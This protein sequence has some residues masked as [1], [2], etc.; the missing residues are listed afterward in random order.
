MAYA[1]CYKCNSE[2][3]DPTFAESVLMKIECWSCGH[4]HELGH[5]ESKEALISLE[6]RITAIEQHL[7]LNQ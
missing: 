5:D 4:D 2:L 1:Y 6:E 7:G 3:N